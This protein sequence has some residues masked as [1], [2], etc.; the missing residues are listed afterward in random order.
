MLEMYYCDE[1]V[2]SILENPSGLEFAG[3]LDLEEFKTLA[4]CFKE[5]ESVG[6]SICFFE[7]HLMNIH[8]VEKVLFIFIAVQ[9]NV[10]HIHH[11]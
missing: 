8:Q 7:D 1:R 6:I 11:A 4:A 2:D 10:A 3:G 9:F 5:C